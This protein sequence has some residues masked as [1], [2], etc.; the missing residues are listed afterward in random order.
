MAPDQLPDNLYGTAY[1]LPPQ[2]WDDLA[3]RPPD[4]AA[5]A[6]GAEFKD[7]LF[8]LP[9]LGREYMVDPKGRRIQEKDRPEAV[10]DFQSGM[11][12]ISTL[13]RAVHTPPAG[14]MVTPKQLPGG[15]FFFTGPHAIPTGRLCKHFG[16]DPGLLLKRA[17]KMGGRPMD[18]ADAAVLL[19][20]L[21]RLPLYVFLWAADDEFQASATVGLDAHAHFHLA[22]DGL[23]AL[24]NVL[25]SRLIQEN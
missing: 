19:Q 6:T 8:F 4:D 25:V 2:L 23:W 16:N 11:V 17:A 3:A 12:L 5:R 21:P 22:L 14:R 9:L 1:Q 13:G 15:S 20:G 24:S 7:G 18:G 10:V